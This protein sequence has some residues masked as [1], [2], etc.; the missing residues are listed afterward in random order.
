M[1]NERCCFPSCEQIPFYY[2]KC[3]NPPL[4]ICPGHRDDHETT[5]GAF[6]EHSTMPLFSL[7]DENELSMVKRSHMT[8]KAIQ[9]MAIDQVNTEY[10]RRMAELQRQFQSSILSIFQI[11]DPLKQNL[12]QTLAKPVISRLHPDS[13][14]KTIIEGRSLEDHEKDKYIDGVIKS[15]V[16]RHF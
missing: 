1:Q 7:L 14:L 8:V 9:N 11:I 15:L 4:Y 6:Q 3:N 5:A 13:F 10:Q 12:K 2:C 16:E